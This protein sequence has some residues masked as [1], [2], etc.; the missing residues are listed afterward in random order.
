MKSLLL[1]ALAVALP[2]AA[3]EG[4]FDGSYRMRFNADSNLLLDDQSFASGQ[5]RWVEHRLRLTPTRRENGE[6]GGIEIQASFDI[7]SGLFAGDTAAD[8]RGY[9]LTGRSERTGLKAEGFDF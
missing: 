1:V 5:K 4:R 7:F 2:A 6:K 8:F 9:G 3:A